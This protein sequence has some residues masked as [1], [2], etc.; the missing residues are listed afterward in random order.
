MDGQRHVCLKM[1]NVFDE[2]SLNLH[3]QQGI[4]SAPV[5]FEKEVAEK[6]AFVILRHLLNELP[7]PGMEHFGPD[8]H[9]SHFDL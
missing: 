5:F 3:P 8:A 1:V 2:S 4:E 6:G 9:H 7:C